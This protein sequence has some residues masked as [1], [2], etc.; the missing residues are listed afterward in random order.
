MKKNLFSVFLAIVLSFSLTIRAQVLDSTMAVVSSGSINSSASV[1]TMA[2]LNNTIY[3]GGSF[4]YVGPRTGSGVPVDI[5]T[6][7]AKAQFPKVN[8]TIYTI[9]SDGKGGWFMGGSFKVINAADFAFLVH[10]NPNYSLDKSWNPKVKSPIY[11]LLL[12]NNILYV[13]G[14]F[15]SIG[16]TQRNNIAAIDITSGQITHWN[17][18]ADYEV[19]TILSANNNIIVGGRFTQIGGAQRNFLALLDPVTGLASPWNAFID[20]G[21]STQTYIK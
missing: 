9:I 10:I 11:T 20:Q 4:D 18:N 12:S 6:G 3:L 7:L 14:S 13:G 21:V 16:D 8:G 19:K 17:P 2:T 5:A 15:S 1:Y